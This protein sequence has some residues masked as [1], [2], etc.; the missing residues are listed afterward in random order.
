MPRIHF[1][2]KLSS[3][4]AAKRG[5]WGDEETITLLEM[6]VAHRSI[7]YRQYRGPGGPE[8]KDAVWEVIVGK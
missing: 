1:M 5:W 4:A 6:A 2:V 3:R 8:R 7:V